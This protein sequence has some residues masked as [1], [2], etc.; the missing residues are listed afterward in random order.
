MVVSY[1]FHGNDF[2]YD[3]S[4][5]FEGMLPAVNNPNVFSILRERGY[6]ADLIC[7]SGYQHVRPI[8][9]QFLD[10]RTAADLGDA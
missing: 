9:L 7:L 5:E 3:T 10:R 8:E 2:E 4:S 1:L 6:H